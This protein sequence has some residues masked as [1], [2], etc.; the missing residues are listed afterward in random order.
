MKKILP[1]SILLLLLTSC[2]SMRNNI[3]AME[4]TL[5]AADTLALRYV[6]LPLCNSVPTGKACADIGIVAN[7]GVAEVTVHT[8]MK[9][10]EVAQ[11]QASVDKAQTALASLQQLLAALKVQ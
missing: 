10:A 2:N 5:T 6:D 11:D 4:V 9:A 8:A 1:L 3:A 7:I